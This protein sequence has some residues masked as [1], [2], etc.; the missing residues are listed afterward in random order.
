MNEPKESEFDML[1]ADAVDK[2]WWRVFAKTIVERRDSLLNKLV[3]GDG[4]NREAENILRGRIQELNFMVQIDE[5]A[6][7]Q[8]KQKLE[9]AEK[10]RRHGS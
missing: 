7:V 2:P 4:S 1:A 6:K 5:R 10:E 3:A 9:N 8:N